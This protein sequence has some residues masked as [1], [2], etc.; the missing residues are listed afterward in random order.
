MSL[1]YTQP[2]DDDDDDD[3]DLLG[4]ILYLALISTV[5]LFLQGFL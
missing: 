2:D 3:D 4:Y 5:S 1:K